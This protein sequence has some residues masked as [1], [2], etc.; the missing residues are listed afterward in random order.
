MDQHKRVVVRHSSGER[1]TTP[2]FSSLI[3]WI[4]LRHW[5]DEGNRKISR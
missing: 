1:R 3:E 5:N 4:L 2:R